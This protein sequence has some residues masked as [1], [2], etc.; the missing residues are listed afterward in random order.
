MA[1]CLAAMRELTA[2]VERNVG[3]RA[4]KTTAGKLADRHKAVLP[5][6]DDPSNKTKGSLKSSPAVKAARGAKGR[7]AVAMVIDDVAAVPGEFGTSKMKSHL[8]VRSTTDAM[9]DDLAATL[10]AALKEE[11]DA[12][13]RRAA[14]KGK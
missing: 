3:K 9:R 6:S 1:G 11:A 14:K 10:G 2:T 4:L 12:A 13:A 5:V 8:K 7:P